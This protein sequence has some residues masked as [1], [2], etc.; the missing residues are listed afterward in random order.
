MRASV[1]PR[2]LLPVLLLLLLAKR[3]QTHRGFINLA[4]A[5]VIIDAA[6][7]CI[8]IQVLGG[9]LTSYYQGLNIIVMGMIVVIPFAFRESII[10][11]ALTWAFYAVPSF[12]KVI[13]GQ[14]PVTVDGAAMKGTFAMRDQ[15]IE[16]TA[17]KK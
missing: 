13:L 16:W 12:I 15:E 5:L 6:G 8:M 3:T 11:Y 10:L 9:F 17:K 2:P 4:M 14:D 7:I 1:S